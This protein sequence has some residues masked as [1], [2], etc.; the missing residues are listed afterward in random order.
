MGY[1]Q[2]WQQVPSGARDPAAFIQSLCLWFMGGLAV[3]ALGAVGA[4][5]VARAQ[6]PV[7][8]PFFRWGLF[9]VPFGTLLFASAR[10]VN[11]SNIL[12]SPMN[13]LGGGRRR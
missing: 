2:P 7:V 1:Q 4:P 3:A 9:G 6:V 10:F 13:L 11:L 12:I 5:M 8:G